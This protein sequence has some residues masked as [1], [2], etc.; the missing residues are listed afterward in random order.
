MRL[1]IKIENSIGQNWVVRITDDDCGQ[2]HGWQSFDSLALACTSAPA[3]LLKVQRK[4]I[5]ERLH[6]LTSN[7]LRGN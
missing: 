5:A 7:A 4:I 1:S 3:V 6:L 2:E